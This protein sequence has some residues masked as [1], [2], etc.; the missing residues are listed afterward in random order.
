[1]KKKG[2]IIENEIKS[3]YTTLKK[4]LFVS[5]FGEMK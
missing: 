3:K 2:A 5:V 1:M 4:D